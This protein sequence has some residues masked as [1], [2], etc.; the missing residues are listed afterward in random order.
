M[1]VDE[2]V[3]GR[4]AA[5]GVPATAWSILNVLSSCPVTRN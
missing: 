4:R 2:V 1:R 5:V 3:V